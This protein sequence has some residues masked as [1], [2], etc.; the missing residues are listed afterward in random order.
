MTIAARKALANCKTAYDLEAGSEAARFRVS[1]VLGVALLRS[2]GHVLRKID[3]ERDPCIA[4][5]VGTA[6][7][8]CKANKEM[9]A[10][11]WEFIEEEPNNILKEYEFGF[12]SG[13]ID[14]LVTP[15]GTLFALDNNLFC[16]VANGRFAGEDC[17]DVL[18]EAT[19]W[20]ERQLSAIDLHKR[21]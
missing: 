9:N 3:S 4:E 18:A 5:A 7:E 16:P 15:G 1:W 20:W 8:R 19:A 13:H 14:I 6:W 21:G 17:R 10:V 12:L 11:F 2:V